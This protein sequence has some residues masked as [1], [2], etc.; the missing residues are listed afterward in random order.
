VG[1]G[2]ERHRTTGA[3]TRL[4]RPNLVP[5]QLDDGHRGGVALA[6]TDLRDPGVAA[7]TVRHRRPDLGEQG[8]DDTVSRAARTPVVGQDHRL[9]LATS[10]QVTALGE[11]DQLLRVRAQATRARLGRGDLPVLEE[12]GGQVRQHVLLVSRAATHPGTLG[13][14]GH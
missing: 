9:H 4:A 3:A 5:D 10:V 12:S 14:R 8:V 2:R 6:V 11:G 1:T 13:R 7:G